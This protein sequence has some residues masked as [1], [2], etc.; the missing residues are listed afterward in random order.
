MLSYIIEIQ[1]EQGAHSYF[2]YD[3][4]SGG[5]PWFPNNMFSAHSFNNL[6]NARKEYAD[7]VN[8]NGRISEWC[9]GTKG[10]P[11]VMRQYAELGNA[12]TGG[13]FVVKLIA[14]EGNSW[15]SI[16]P[17]ILMAH[18]VTI[19]EFLKERKDPIIT[20]EQVI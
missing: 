6:E 16:K 7:L 1:N 13:R 11:A 12:R 3:A 8:E 17:V 18:S 15:S 4:S 9:D 2:A 10:A 19:Q 14:L 5:Y 20:S